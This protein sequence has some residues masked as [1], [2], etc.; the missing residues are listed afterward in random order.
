MAD[1]QPLFLVIKL[2]LVLVPVIISAVS[3]SKLVAAHDE[4]AKRKLETN[5][6]A[7]GFISIDC[8]ANEGRRDNETGIFYETDAGYVDTGEVHQISLHDFVHNRYPQKLKN[9]RSFPQ[10][11]RNCYTLKLEQGTNNNYL[12]R[13]VF[14]YGNY[15]NKKQKP[16]FD[17][18]IGVNK[19][20]TVDSEFISCEIINV[21]SNESIDVCLIN[22]G[23]GVPYISV[24]EL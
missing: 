19:W 18:Y 23:H 17:L 22:T 16:V 10:G 13:A 6:N 1:G 20:A 8:G 5:T 14:A 24:L 15:D 11:T 21:F 7:S 4:Q 3:N 2:W 9:L 12:I